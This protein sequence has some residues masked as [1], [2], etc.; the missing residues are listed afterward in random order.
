MARRSRRHLRQSPDRKLLDREAGVGRVEGRADD[1]ASV[2]RGSTTAGVDEHGHPRGQELP[3]LAVASGD[4]QT[5][6]AIGH[7][8]LGSVGACGE[9]M[10]GPPLVDRGLVQPLRV[11]T[12]AGDRRAHAGDRRG[13]TSGRLNACASTMTHRPSRDTKTLLIIVK[14]SNRASFGIRRTAC[15]TPVTTT[16]VP[17]ASARRSWHAMDTTS[18][19]N[20]VILSTNASRS[21][22]SSPG[23]RRTKSSA[24][25]RI[26]ASGLL[27]RI[28]PHTSTRC[29]S[30][31]SRAAAPFIGHHPVLRATYASSSAFRREWIMLC[32]IRNALDCSVLGHAGQHPDLDGSDRNGRLLEAPSA[33]RRE[34]RGKDLPDRRLRRPGHVAVSFQGLEQ[35]VHRLPC[36]ER[37]PRELGVRQARALSQQL[38]AGVVRHAHPERPQHL[39]HGCA[40][41]ARRL[42]QQVAQ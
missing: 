2:A 31:T 40:E 26:H 17:N 23:V 7:G 41:G 33:A 29:T 25:T 5:W 9:R 13:L 36:H 42:F 20:E 12:S 35:H 28:A 6:D 18:P 3:S 37:S 32:R 14:S 38:E 39:L 11:L 10:P 24:S 22:S 34:P 21:R 8:D 16:A 15:C 19:G 1:G 27:A 30:S 4:V